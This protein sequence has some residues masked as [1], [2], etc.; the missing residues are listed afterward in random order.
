MELAARHVSGDG[1][2]CA[3]DGGCGLAGGVGISQRDGVRAETSWRVYRQRDVVDLAR[4]LGGERLRV[5]RVVGL[6]AE[7]ELGDHR[8][9]DRG[10]CGGMRRRGRGKRQQRHQR[11]HERPFSHTFP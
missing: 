8:L 10:A 2:C 7:P 4:D 6:P 11:T 9:V 5:V 1:R 3:Q